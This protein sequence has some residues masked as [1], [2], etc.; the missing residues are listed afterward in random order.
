[1]TL[2]DVDSSTIAAIGYEAGDLYNLFH[3]GST[4][5]RYP[6][7]PYS[8]FEGFLDA[9]SKGDYYHRYIEGRY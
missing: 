6:G 4:I 2:I 5:Y 8:V 9:S 7:V 3:T 1:M